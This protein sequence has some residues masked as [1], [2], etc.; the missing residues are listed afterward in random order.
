MS[1][2]TLHIENLGSL[3]LACKGLGVGDS[4]VLGVVNGCLLEKTTLIAPEEG[5]SMI[6]L[7]LSIDVGLNFPTY[8]ASNIQVLFGSKF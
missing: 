3:I 7:L 8:G 6:K 2:A 4:C 5:K 1:S